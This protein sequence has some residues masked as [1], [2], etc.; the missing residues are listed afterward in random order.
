MTQKKWQLL[1]TDAKLDLMSKTLGI[2]QIT[3][4]VMANRNL[5]SKKT[6]LAFLSP[7]LDAMYQ[8]LDMEGAQVVLER[9]G[10]SIDRREKTVIYGDYDVDGIMST[11][12]LQKVLTRLGADVSYYI[13]HR[14]EE[15]YGLNKN[16][17]TKLAADGVK[18]IIA[19]DNGVSAIEEVELAVSLGVDVLI[20]DHHEQGEN[21]P[22]AVGIVDPKQQGCNYPFK[23]MCAAGLV[24][25]IVSAL[26]KHLNAPFLERDE[27]L[28]LAA[29]ATVCDIVPLTDENRII[30]NCGMTIL[31]ANKLINPGLGSLITLRGYLDKPIDT[32]TVS[33]VIGPC[34]NATGRLESASLSVDLLLTGE[35]DRR[36]IELAHKLAELN[37]ERKSLTADCVERVM[38]GVDMQN[39]DKVL[40]ICDTEAHESIA[41]IVAGR[42][43]EATNRPTILLTRGDGEMKGSGRSIPAFNLFEALNANRDLF[44]RFGGH[45]MA[46]GITMTAE[47]IPILREALNRECQLTDEDFCP[48]LYVDR[49]LKLDEVT[50]ALS[51]ELA[52]LVPFGKGNEEPLFVSRGVFAE[53]VRIIDEKNTLIFTFF[54]SMGKLKGIAF[55][56][57]QLYAE[58][59][60]EKNSELTMDVVYAVETNV[61]NGVASVQMRI[62]DFRVSQAE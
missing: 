6:A 8:T 29:I 44:L 14:Q 33:F 56:L 42:V 58:R 5:R 1:E 19:V 50:L 28:T 48:V 21:L 52:R 20:I 55:G 59:V 31:N 39:P 24:F 25:K 30:V 60:G 11:V 43:R 36:R 10:T 45:A 7:S 4:N 9:I 12:I 41:G 15:G 40:V 35:D 22:P 17:V 61:Y 32:F 34:L 37:E 13:P 46:A 51:D 18:L 49:E 16:A 57:N 23:E 2:S 54:T 62:R 47:N 38:E 3:A 26:C 53:N 27:M